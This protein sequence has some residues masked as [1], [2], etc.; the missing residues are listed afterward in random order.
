MTRAFVRPLTAAAL[1]AALALAAV[2]SADAARLPSSPADREAS[3][4]RIVAGWALLSDLVG[5]GAYRGVTIASPR[6]THSTEVNRSVG[7]TGSCIDPLGNWYPCANGLQ[8]PPGG[9]MAS[10]NAPTH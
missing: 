10:P 2:P 3:A 7:Q 1:A 8:R 9:L 5:F 4:G 6:D